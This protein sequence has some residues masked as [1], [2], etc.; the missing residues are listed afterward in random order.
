MHKFYKTDDPRQQ[1]QVDVLNEIATNVLNIRDDYCAQF[2]KDPKLIL[3]VGHNEYILMRQ[4]G[5]FYEPRR[6]L[7]P[8]EDFYWFNCLVIRV[9]KDTYCHIALNEP[10]NFIAYSPNFKDLP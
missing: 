7:E 4:F 8:S 6:L 10:L 9:F 3:Y 1:A 2:Y 5:D